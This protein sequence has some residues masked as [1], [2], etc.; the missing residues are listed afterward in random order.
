MSLQTGCSVIQR[1]GT[2]FIVNLAGEPL[3]AFSP[4]AAE[5]LAFQ[6][7]DAI[8]ETQ[9]KEPMA[10]KVCAEVLLKVLGKGGD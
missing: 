2:I 7:A 4:Q 10:M 8:R 9:G 3:L 6:L 5:M 1:G